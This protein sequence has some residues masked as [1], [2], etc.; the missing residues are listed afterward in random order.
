MNKIDFALVISVEHC[1]PNGDPLNGGYPRQDVDGH[2]YMSSVC[3]KNKIRNRFSDFGE[4][5]LVANNEH[6]SDH[7][8]SIDARIKAEP[9]LTKYSKDK[10]PSE[11]SREACRIWIDVR[12]FGQVFLYKNLPQCTSFPVRGPVSISI[13]TSLEPIDIMSYGI[14]KGTNLSD[15][16]GMD[17][18]TL[19]AKK[20]VNHGAYVAY[21][22]VFPQLA[23]LTGFSDADA[24]LLK[25]AMASIFENDASD[26]RPSGSMGSQLYWWEHDCPTGRMSSLRVHKS[27]HIR[28]QEDFPYYTCSPE[29]IPGVTLSIL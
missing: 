10:D 4:K 1:N 28:P 15:A 26:A 14:T 24:E 6:A 12:T 25:N 3:L 17:S 23:E 21:G 9:S 7:H 27:L 5:I 29:D 22:S 11:F 2:G 19:G 16:P 20:I 8:Y 13:A 18:S